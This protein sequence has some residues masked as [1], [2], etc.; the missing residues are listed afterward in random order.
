MPTVQIPATRR[1]KG[2][3]PARRPTIVTMG[4]KPAK[5]VPGGCTRATRPCGA[6]F[7]M[8]L[9]TP[10]CCIE[11]HVEILRHV[12]PLLDE[13][14]VR[15][16]IDYGMLLGYAV[17]GGFYWNDR[18]IDISVLAEDKN[19]VLA[20]GARLRKEQKYLVR[21]IPPNL[22]KLWRY[23]DCLKI[24]NSHSNLATLDITFWYE[25]GDGVLD[26]LTYASVDK[27][28]GREMPGDWV[29]PVQRGQWEGLDVA[30]PAEFRKL[31]EYRYGENWWA[32][33][34]AA[35]VDRVERHN[36][37]YGRPRMGCE[38]TDWEGGTLFKYAKLVPAD[39]AIVEV[40]AYQ[41]RSMCWL[42]DGS[43]QGNGAP[44]F[45][46]D[47]WLEHSGYTPTQAGKLVRRNYN[48]PE[49]KAHYERLRAQ[50]GHGLV[51]PLQGDSTKV[52]ASFTQPVGMVFI[53]G[54]HTYKGVM[55]D[56]RAWVPKLTPG[57]YLCFHDMHS[58]GVLQAIGETIG[59]PGSGWK[60]IER[61]RLVA[62]YARG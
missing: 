34:V 42:A 13:A 7:D 1:K 5:Y 11:Q 47:L 8:T 22:Q 26:R 50:F 55:A 21:Y 25:R 60:Q 15:W 41:G 24:T 3:R 58:R 49:T 20:I 16:W 6:R 54:D 17:N 46:V 39:E 44:V 48:A 30:V 43:F 29:F 53:D 31:V 38:V 35:R 52:A 36:T 12:A 18:D 61:T 4:D 45:S 19:K 57:G 14:G 28:K 37:K 23:S 32:L 40:G 2:A 33:P 51:T 62:V 9:A 10:R 56:L 59:K 27:Y